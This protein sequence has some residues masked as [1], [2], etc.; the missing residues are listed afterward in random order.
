MAPLLPPCRRLG[1]RRRRGRQWHG[2]DPRWR[3]ASGMSSLWQGQWRQWSSRRRSAPS[4]DRIRVRTVGTV[5]VTNLVTL[6]TGPSPPIYGTAQREPASLA[7][8]WVLPIRA[9][10]KG[11][12]VVGP[13]GG[14]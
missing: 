10:D 7:L 4:L 12:V 11:P 5:V 3:P 9:R 6:A 1:G 13:T 8:G 2:G 14:D